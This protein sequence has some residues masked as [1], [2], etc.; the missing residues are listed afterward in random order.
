MSLLANILI[1]IA[2]L[3]VFATLIMGFMAML[4]RTPE[5]RIRSNKMMRYRVYAQGVAIVVFFIA[6]LMKKNGG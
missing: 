3:A 6:V 5:G 2:L 1:I 4:D